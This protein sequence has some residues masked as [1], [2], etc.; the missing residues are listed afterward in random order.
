MLCGKASAR[1][2]LPAVKEEDATTAA[3]EQGQLLQVRSRPWVV[4]EV[5]PSNLPYPAME[6]ACAC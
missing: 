2:A 3:S 5:K 1:Y 6:P 4:N